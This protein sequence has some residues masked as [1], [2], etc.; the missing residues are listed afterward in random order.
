M[1]TRRGNKKKVNPVNVIA[2]WTIHNDNNDS[3]REILGLRNRNEPVL[4]IIIFVIF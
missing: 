1:F 3:G 2:R 4:N